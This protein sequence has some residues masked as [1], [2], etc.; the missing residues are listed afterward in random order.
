[1]MFF[2]TL[3][4]S[5]NIFEYENEAYDKDSIL[6][7][8]AIMG[9]LCLTFGITQMIL[10]YYAVNGDNNGVRISCIVFLILCYICFTVPA[11]LH[12]NRILKIF[13]TEA[14]GWTK[15]KAVTYFLL[16]KLIF[17]AR[18][19]L[20]LGY[21]PC[22]VLFNK[23]KPRFIEEFGT[24]KYYLQGA[25]DLATF[26]LTLSHITVMYQGLD[27][28]TCFFSLMRGDDKKKKK[29]NADAVFLRDNDPLLVSHPNNNNNAAQ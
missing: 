14:S 23:D 4:K 24:N 18:V 3:G 1:M 20:Y 9:C 22:L 2:F 5:M 7:F 27:E 15:F 25:T 11:V 21:Y 8:L 12:W 19:V 26:L 6:G 16:T 17:I 29:N 13:K 10:M 28:Y